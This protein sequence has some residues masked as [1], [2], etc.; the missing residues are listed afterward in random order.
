MR[1]FSSGF[2]LAAL[3]AAAFGTSG[4]FAAALL[5]AGWSTGAAVTVRVAVAALLLTVPALFVLRGRW[6]LVRRGLPSILA[7]GLVAIA[8]CQF[9]YFNAVEHLS[10]GVA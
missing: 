1:G 5:A 2:G 7:F 8:G 9:F 4:T 3:S 10:V 6:G